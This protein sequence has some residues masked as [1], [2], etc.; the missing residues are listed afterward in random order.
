VSKTEAP[1]FDYVIIGG[2]SAG[3]VLAN[4]L[5]EN[6]AHRVL[7]LEA[8]PRRSNLWIDMP[9]GLSKAI[10][11][12]RRNWSYMA[13]P[14]AQIKNRRVF[15]PRGKVLG[16]SS[17]LNG[18]V[19]VRGQHEDYEQW[20]QSGNRGWGWDDVL[21]YFR[22]SEHRETG[23][24]AYHG[25][26]GPL[27]VTDSKRR[28]PIAEK[29]IASG[30]ALGLKRN[31]DANGADQEGIG[32]LQYTIRQGKRH[33]TASAFIDPVKYRPNLTIETDAMVDR[34]LLDGRRATG[35][36]YRVHAEVRRV[37]AGREI[38]LAAGSLNSPKLLM[39]SGIGPADQLQAL[40]IAV[41]HDLPGV[42]QNLQ[43]HFYVHTTWDTVPGGSWNQELRGWR[44]IMH[45][46]QWLA[47]H[48]GL[49]TMGSSQAC[50][51]ARVMPGADRPDFQINFR[52]VS[53]D[54][55]RQDR[56]AIGRT[57]AVTASS[58]QLRPQSRGEIRLSSADPEAPPSIR[59]HYLSAVADQ[60]AVIGGFRYMR[61]IFET[62]PLRDLMVAETMPGSACLSDADL[63]DYIRSNANSMHHWSGT[64]KMGQDPMAVV[65]D[66]LRVH[67]IAGLR[68]IDASVM[69]TL[70]SGNT[71]APTIMV[72]EK[73]SDL[74]KQDAA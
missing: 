66:R 7:L 40:G 28:H 9:A 22:K 54:F 69:P 57:P 60:L 74:I 30:M 68:V 33:S 11:P 3:C 2:G 48:T 55:S 38:I 19:Y 34:I 70:V 36:E 50:A 73:G 42:G 41:A 6:P 14:D 72:A 26:G 16:G 15:V 35:V 37:G 49:L 18:M 17:A 53:W 31:D 29:F 12:N 20:R 44:V 58:C 8:G 39:L 1:V 52:P 43:D 10:F 32:Y 67:G 23:G 64:C 13:E 62:S 21:P 65:D 5:S 56:L 51:F 47:T 24:D 63:L 61:Q 46:L 27:W 25:T 71:N 45:G 59:P 4:R